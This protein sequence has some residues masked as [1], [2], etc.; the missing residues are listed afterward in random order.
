MSGHAAPNPAADKL[1]PTKNHP[2]SCW[3]TERMAWPIAATAQDRITANGGWSTML[4]RLEIL[5]ST[6]AMYPAATRVNACDTLVIA[7]ATGVMVDV[8]NP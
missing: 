8:G 6:P 7:N 2:R 3:A 4:W 1:D 5:I